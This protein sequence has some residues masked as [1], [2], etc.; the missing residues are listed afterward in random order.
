MTIKLKKTKPNKIITTKT[1]NMDSNSE[2]YYIEDVR[3]D[4]EQKNVDE[5]KTILNKVKKKVIGVRRLSRSLNEPT[6]EKS[7]EL[8][9]IKSVVGSSLSEFQQKCA[10]MSE[11]CVIN[12]IL[13][14]MK[15]NINDHLQQEKGCFSLWRLVIE[16]AMNANYIIQHDGIEIILNA[17]N[18]HRNIPKLQEHACGLM[19]QMSYN[20]ENTISQIGID[21]G[22]PVIVMSMNTHFVDPVVMERGISALCNLS[23]NRKENCDIIVENGGLGLLLLALNHYQKDKNLVEKI[24]HCIRH[25]TKLNE[26]SR[27]QFVERDG[28]ELL[29]SVF[30]SCKDKS[31]IQ[32]QSCSIFSHIIEKNGDTKLKSKILE[33]GLIPLLSDKMDALIDESKYLRMVSNLFYH[34]SILT[35]EGNNDMVERAQIE[36]FYSNA[37]SEII[38]T[39]A[40]KQ[41]AS[42][43]KLYA[44]D[45]E[46][47]K[48]S[49]LVLRN[50]C[51][52]KDGVK[53][54]KA[55]IPK[56]YF[57]QA[58]LKHPTCCSKS[59]K[60]ILEHV[61]A[62]ED[63][64]CGSCFNTNIVNE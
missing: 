11:S 4:V 51:F 9:E 28:I 12:L 60:T 32:A 40:I 20:N 26:A 6:P 53:K 37:R 42:V 7:T 39:N 27:S 64:F 54:I 17:M 62:D 49:C 13:T 14:A 46:L 35:V 38:K 47:L 16:E 45:A 44:N 48:S 43:F 63:T 15:V 33:N 36:M 55:H 52:G 24:V 1:S 41:Y 57:E 25:L 59:V 31:I 21:G 30:E 61:Y 56:K 29:A 19:G 2:S 18:T 34:L 23:F 50:L 5:K 8:Y 10:I 22:I 3:D 58:A